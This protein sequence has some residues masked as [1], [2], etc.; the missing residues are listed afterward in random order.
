MMLCCAEES[1]VRAPERKQPGLQLKKGRAV[2]MT[3]DY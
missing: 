1:Q 3:H 2:T